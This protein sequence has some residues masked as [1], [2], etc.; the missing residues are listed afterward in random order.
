M[1]RSSKKKRGGLYPLF[2]L[3]L[4]FGG[5]LVICGNCHPTA[6]EMQILLHGEKSI[7][8]THGNIPYKINVV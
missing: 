5:F 3:P 1:S 2:L 7:R 8:I 6:K 4:R